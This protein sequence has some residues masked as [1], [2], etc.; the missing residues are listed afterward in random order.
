MLEVLFTIYFVWS[1]AIA[2]AAAPRF[3]AGLLVPVARYDN[4]TG[5]HSKYLVGPNIVSENRWIYTCLVGFL[6]TV[7]P[8]INY[9]PP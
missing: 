4:I 8:I 6:C 2:V 3:S 9:G 1:P 7:G 5:D